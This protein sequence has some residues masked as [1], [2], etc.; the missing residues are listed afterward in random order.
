MRERERFRIEFEA[1]SE[2]QFSRYIFEV[3][4]RLLPSKQLSPAD[5]DMH[6]PRYPLLLALLMI[7]SPVA[8]GIKA[9][10]STM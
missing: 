5:V 9:L 10:E 6:M 2:E 7:T 8:I 4:D 3:W 1:I